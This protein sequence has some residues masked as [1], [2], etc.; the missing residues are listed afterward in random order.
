MKALTFVQEKTIMKSLFLKAAVL[1]MATGLSG[2]AQAISLL[3]DD[4]NTDQLVSDVAG[5]S[6]STQAENNFSGTSL[7][8]ADRTVT[9]NAI[10]NPGIGGTAR[11]NA[12][13][14]N[15]LPG[16]GILGISANSA[17]LGGTVQIT[18]NG[19]ASTDFTL[20]GTSI[21]MDVVSVDTGVSV[22]VLV[23]G[24]STSGTVPFAGSGVFDVG[25]NEFSDP[26]VFTHVT[27]IVFTFS[28]S[29]P[30]DANFQLLR[31]FNNPE[32]ATLFLLGAGFAGMAARIR[33]KSI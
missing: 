1:T 16:D 24:T 10:D 14:T 13:F 5:G 31:V 19:F 11:L 27:S 12:E 8:G 17:S 33:R 23:N 3:I 21:A 25:F 26:S 29:T 28:G 9:V 7:V 4:F 18:Y 20:A 30:Y 2:T 6:P 15:G 22:S 32:P